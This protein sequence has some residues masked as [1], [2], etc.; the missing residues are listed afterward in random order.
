MS[1]RYVGAVGFA[2]V[3]GLL[4]SVGCSVDVKSGVFRCRADQENTCPAGW[5]CQIRGAGGDWRCYSSAGGHC[6]DENLDDDEICDG[7]ALRQG[8]YCAMGGYPYCLSDCTVSCTVCGDG[9]LESTQRGEREECDDNN[10]VPGDGCAPDCKLARCGD[11]FVDDELHEACDRGEHNSDAADAE[12]RKNCQPRRCGDGIPDTSETCDDGNQF[13]RDGCTPD[14]ASD[15]SCGNEYI[16]FLIGELC[17]DGNNLSHDGCANGCLIEDLSWTAS[18]IEVPPARYHHAMVYDSRR[19]RAMVFGGD[20]EAGNLA[21]TWEWDG[22]RWYEVTPVGLSPPRRRRHAM[23]WD[24]A[25]G[26]VVLF[27]GEDRGGAEVLDDTWEWNGTEWVVVAPSGPRPQ[28]R[29]NHAMAYDPI[30]RRVILFGGRA[31]T[32]LGGQ[33]LGDTWAWD[34]RVWVNLSSIPSP[35]PRAGHVMALH[36]DTGGIV[37]F[38]GYHNGLLWDTWEWA[39]G[40]WHEVTQPSRSPPAQAYSHLVSDPYRGVLLLIVGISNEASIGDTWTWDGGIW[41]EVVSETARPRNGLYTAV[42]F[43]VKRGRALIFGGYPSRPVAYFWEWNGQ[44]WFE[45]LYSRALPSPRRDPVFVCIESRGHCLMYGG[46]DSNGTLRD[47][48]IWEANTWRDVT[49]EATPAFRAPAAYDS[50][51][52]RVVMFGDLETW[53]WYDGAWHSIAIPA[54]GPRPESVAVSFFHRGRERVV[55]IDGSGQIWEWTGAVWIAAPEATTLVPSAVAYDSHRDRAVAVVGTRTWE[56][57]SD[58]WVDVTPLTGVPPARTGFAMAYDPLRRRVVLQGGIIGD[59]PRVDAWEWNGVRWDELTRLPPLSPRYAHAMVYD[60][61]RSRLL[62]FGGYSI[63]NDGPL[64]DMWEV[65]VSRRGAPDEVCVSGADTDGDGLAG[66]ADPDC[67]ARCSPHCPPEAA[68][69]STAAR[70]GDGA[71]G[72]LEGCRLCPDDCGACPSLCGD[73]VCEEAEQGTECPADCAL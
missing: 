57:S 46:R 14:C 62:I 19:A 52:D 73:F 17:D 16:D 23:A 61:L 66:C 67:W 60:G 55:V 21:D 39:S 15:E 8:N 51:R 20:S 42:T 26:R 58:G 10:D 63:V 13:A 38:G 71:C 54:N 36:P 48:W 35:S 64:N 44:G 65:R 24:P 34:G 69:A 68:C 5:V 18:V 9:K 33:D 41:R 70:C 45:I 12:C 1:L 56:L 31:L 40:Q 6:G 30:S 22:E 47:T 27:G 3:C 72:V 32:D 29:F 43:D 4:M 53:E 49:G 28:A 37:L 59:S 50:R 7:S 11:G 2:H 25:R